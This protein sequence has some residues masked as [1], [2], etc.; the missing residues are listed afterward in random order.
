MWQS[1]LKADI[2]ENIHKKA[3]MEIHRLNQ[4]N[5][6][7]SGI[8]TESTGRLLGFQEGS[9]SW[10]KAVIIARRGLKRKE[11]ASGGLRAYSMV[12]QAER[13]AARLR[14][15]RLSQRPAGAEIFPERTTG[16]KRP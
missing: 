6:Q 7:D 2:C 15:S 14:A 13:T 9:W 11:A 10:E 12:A 3:A 1:S 16:R 5:L 8:L 4:Q